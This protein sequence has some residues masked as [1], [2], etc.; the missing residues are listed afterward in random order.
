MLLVVGY[1]IDCVIVLAHAF[2]SFYNG[3]REKIAQLLRVLVV[4]GLYGALAVIFSDQVEIP[5]VPLLGCIAP[6]LCITG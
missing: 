3:L 6:V 4:G 2:L 5:A 1:R